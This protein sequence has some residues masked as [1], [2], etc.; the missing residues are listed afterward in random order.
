MMARLRGGRP[1]TALETVEQA[2][3]AEASDALAA[4]LLDALRRRWFVGEAPDVRERLAAFAQA[5]GVD[6]VMISPVAGAYD[7]EPMDTADGRAQ[8]LELLAG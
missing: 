1:L 6:E 4:P 2:A 5:H 8:T 3:A 7:A